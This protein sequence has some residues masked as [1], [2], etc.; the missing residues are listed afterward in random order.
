MKHVVLNT[1]I[2]GDPDDLYALL[3]LLGS[4]NVKIDMIITS[5]EHNSGRASY[6]VKFL[7]ELGQDIPVYCGEDL[8]NTRC[9]LVP[10]H[11][12]TVV[13]K[14]YCEAIKALTKRFTFLCIS[15]QSEL[16]K[17]SDI[18]RDRKIPVILMGGSTKKAEH[19]VRYN[20]PA[21]LKVL[22]TLPNVLWVPSDITVNDRIKIDKNHLLYKRITHSKTPAA[23]YLKEN[24]DAFFKNLFPDHYLHDPLAISVL[25]DKE[26][27]TFE[28][29]LFQLTNS[30]FFPDSN[31]FPLQ[32]GV[33][34]DYDRFLQDF[35][36]KIEQWL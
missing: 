25:V 13:S 28:H 15:P 26:I 1:D 23:S 33:K 19:N 6:L 3:F 29:K 27:I 20:I 36:V 12:Q 21:A 17:A 7:K 16:A 4:S 5:D 34:A 32:Y 9:F 10:D 14:E 11:K 31:G 8:G 18:L 24:T 2:F 35:N 30:Q 22:Q